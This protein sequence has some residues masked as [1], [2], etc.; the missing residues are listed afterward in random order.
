MNY[1]P[2]QSWFPS[3]P[4][5]EDSGC[6]SLLLLVYMTLSLH[7]HLF[8]FWSVKRNGDISFWI[9]KNLGEAF[10]KIYNGSVL[11]WH[12]GKKHVEGSEAYF[13]QPGVMPEISDQWTPLQSSEVSNIG[14]VQRNTGLHI[15]DTIE[16]THQ[17]QHGHLSS[18]VQFWD[19]AAPWNPTTNSLSSIPEGWL[20]VLWAKP[21]FQPLSLSRKQATVTHR[22]LAIDDDLLGEPHFDRIGL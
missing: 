13:T 10:L 6:I 8:P 5:D 22:H 9:R 18:P 1:V 11:T 4:M 2:G 7:L 15:L 21:L 20:A 16:G 3:S 19:L 17:V 12:N 14:S